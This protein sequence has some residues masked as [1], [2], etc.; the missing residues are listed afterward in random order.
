MART[1]I[2]V[3][4]A[5]F[6]QGRFPTVAFINKATTPLGVNLDKLV[7][8]LQKQL[9]QHFVPV[10]GY[11]AKLHVTAE[12]EADEWQIVFLDDADAAN[13]LGYH[14]I[15]K[16]G[17]PISKVFVKTT[18]AANQRVSTTASHE[19][20]EMLIDPAAQ[21]WAQNGDGKLYAY[22]MC[23]AV[24]SEEYEIDGIAVSN[25]VHPSFFESWHLP[26]SV[27]FDHLKKVTRPFET[28][29]NGYQ[30]VTDGK[31]VQEVFGS[32]NKLLDFQ[33]EVRAMH[34]SEYRKHLMEVKAASQAQA[35]DSNH[36]A[37][38]YHAGQFLT[39]LA[40][41]KKKSPEP[42]PPFTTPWDTDPPPD[43]WRFP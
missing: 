23:D 14:D 31:S 11:P 8:A 15:T 19:L 43:P 4:A 5:A 40:L 22:E 33:R 12:P 27:Q 28:L 10:W 38:L 26:R 9:D 35:R 17:Q 32:E 18:L 25:F 36:A 29:P 7:S 13:A 37:V 2:S 24:E 21:L 3:K 1:S 41:T 6:N 34:R 20:L 16:D 30:I 39:A 42:L